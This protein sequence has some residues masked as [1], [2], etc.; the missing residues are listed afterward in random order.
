MA[1]QTSVTKSVCSDLDTDPRRH[2]LFGGFNQRRE[3]QQNRLPYGSDE[4]I[5]LTNKPNEKQ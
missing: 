4:G 2:H 1:P 3:E 5:R